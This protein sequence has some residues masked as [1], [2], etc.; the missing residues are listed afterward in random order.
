MNVNFWG[1]GTELRERCNFC[2]VLLVTT[3][4]YYCDQFGMPVTLITLLRGYVMLNP[5]GNLLKGT[6]LF[7]LTIAD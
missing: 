2:D 7:R 6:P 3:L 5:D 1:N 4:V